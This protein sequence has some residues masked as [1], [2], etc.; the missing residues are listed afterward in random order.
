MRVKKFNSNKEVSLSTRKYA[1]DW[2]N[3]GNSSL[4]RQFRDLI[5]PYWRNYIVLFQLTVPGSLLKLDFLNCNKRLAI[6]IDGP[7][8]D[9]FNKFFHNNSRITWANHMKRD[10]DK[11][12]WC[13]E[14]NI[15]V[16]QLIKEDLDNFSPK[17]IEKRFGVSII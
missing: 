14:N 2:E 1:I 4:E 8:H 12:K 16:I 13:E 3:D 9:K 11:Y 6:E 17:E 7:Q 5:Y 15:K 10:L